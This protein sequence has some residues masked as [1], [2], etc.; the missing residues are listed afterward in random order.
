MQ[1][2]RAVQQQYKSQLRDRRQ[3]AQQARQE[4]ERL[5]ANSASADT[6][7]SKSEEVRQLKKS[8]R[9]IRSQKLLAM[10]ELLTSTQ[11]QQLDEKMRNRPSGIKQNRKEQVSS[12]Q[13][14]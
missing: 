1:R 11:R 4:L 10:R 6:V 12:P 8:L 3:E 14:Y 13:P 7:R 5:Q 9:E 2:L